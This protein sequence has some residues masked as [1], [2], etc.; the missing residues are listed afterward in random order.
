MEEVRTVHFVT[1]DPIQ[2][3]KVRGVRVQTSVHVQQQGLQL[4]QHANR[5]SPNNACGTQ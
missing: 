1:K 4:S 2:N 3:L 5:G